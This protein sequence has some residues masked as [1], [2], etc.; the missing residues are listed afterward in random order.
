MSFARTETQVLLGDM[1][2]KLLDAENDFEAR[3]HRLAQKTADR[4]ALWPVLAEQGILGAPFPEEA[5][6]FGG[7]IRDLAVVML[8]VGRKLVVEPVLS[9]AIC[10][11]ILAG[12]R[13]DISGLMEGREV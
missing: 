10:G 4:M 6:G 3:R 7:T 12:A 1:L 2:G 5:G 9:S 8:E 11:R 13:A